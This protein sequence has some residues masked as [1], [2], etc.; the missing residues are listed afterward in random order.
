MRTCR[1]R[2]PFKGGPPLKHEVLG[3]SFELAESQ[4]T[5]SLPAKFHDDAGLL[6]IFSTARAG[7]SQDTRYRNANQMRP[8]IRRM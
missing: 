3:S 7:S 4:L 6:S 2:G 8:N 5:R 1:G